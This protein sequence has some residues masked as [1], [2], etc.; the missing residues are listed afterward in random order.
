MTNWPHRLREIRADDFLKHG[1]L[2]WLVIAGVLLLYIWLISDASPVNWAFF[3]ISS[4]LVISIC[5]RYAPGPVR[6]LFVATRSF[7]M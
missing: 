4:F 2:T 5:E 6:S 7:F 1:A 3:D